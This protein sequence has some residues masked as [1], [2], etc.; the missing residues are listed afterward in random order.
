MI[1]GIM[2]IRIALIVVG[3]AFNTYAAPT[4]HPA[5][6]AP[7]CHD[8]ADRAAAF[9]ADHTAQPSPRG[10]ES[11]QGGVDAY[12]NGKFELA[13]DAWRDSAEA[14]RAAG[15]WEK[16][17][18]ASLKLAGAYQAL[19]NYRPAM[20]VLGPLRDEA[21]RDPRQYML[22]TAASVRAR[23]FTVSHH[24]TVGDPAV[25]L[26]ES[27]STARELN[28]AATEAAILNDL[29]NLHAARGETDLATR[30]YADCAKLA[31]SAGDSLTAARVR[32]NAA[33]MTQPN[34]DR[35]VAA[36]M[37]AAASVDKLTAS[38]DQA[39]LLVAVACRF[40]QLST[41]PARAEQSYRRAIELAGQFDDDRLSSFA[42]GYLGRH[43]ENLKRFDDAMIATRHAR[44][45]AQKMQRDDALYRWEW[46]LGRLHLASGN[47]DAALAAYERAISSIGNNNV[48]NDVALAYAAPVST[49][50]FRTEVGQLYYSMA[51]LL[52]R[53]ADGAKDPQQVQHLLRRARD[54]IELFKAAELT[55]YFEDDCLK[56]AEASK[57]D[58]DA[59][60]QSDPT[61]AVVYVI[62]LKDRI[63][64]LVS[65]AG[66]GGVNQPQ[67]WRADPVKQPA[68]ELTK[69]A[70]EFRERVTDGAEF[71]NASAETL[72]DWLIKPIDTRLRE[73]KIK[74]LV[75]V[76]DGELRSVA[77][78]ALRDR[79]HK[80]YLIED[81]A[82]AIT[83]GLSLSVPTMMTGER[84]VRILAG[85]M[86]Q[87][88]TLTIG[89]QEQSFSALPGVPR[90]LSDVAAIY[91]Q[92]RST[93][94]EDDR[95]LKDNVSRALDDNAYPV[96]HLAT[97]AQF[98]ADVRRTFVVTQDNEPLDMS[99]LEKLI[100]PSQFRGRPVELLSLSA[101]ETATGN[102]GR[103][104]LGLAGVA[105]RAGARSALA[106]LWPA[107]DET[108]ATLIPIFYRELNSSAS[109]SKAQAMQRAQLQLL[110]SPYKNH[111]KFWA[112]FVIVGNWR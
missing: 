38:L 54:A 85:G 77:F 103:A 99:Q 67:I 86:S 48:R 44:F 46:Q 89:G 55:N 82:I 18:D 62:P 102:D 2:S 17:S 87:G 8:S 22:S 34:Q 27:F 74:T 75:F 12:R 105:V 65:V 41:E 20:D 63:E 111:T 13:A 80:R 1:R 104:A 53:Q 23:C 56:L 4:T 88:K 14:Y 81:Y 42:W 5:S 51:D 97:H 39:R 47:T 79:E 58:I 101:C 37:D 9:P 59:A 96:V 31:E 73:R 3:I 26:N 71:D 60:L 61:T 64:V 69:I 32:T 6:E 43:F 109:I 90:E 49:G 107:D 84:N 28:D 92:K 52:L 15:D 40:D 45:A 91:G 93:M 100:Q 94:F 66:E 33:L 10:D 57:K 21:R 68:S 106:T 24:D 16:Y 70:L 25:Y 30:E 35:A 98:N 78:A 19:G 50:N 108:A 76:P 112:P 29:A 72:Y 95:F 36:L 11:M 110:N 83:P 7:V